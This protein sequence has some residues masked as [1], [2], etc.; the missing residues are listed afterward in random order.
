MIPCFE[1][2]NFLPRTEAGN[3]LSALNYR[4]DLFSTKTVPSFFLREHVMLNALLNDCFIITPW[5]VERTLK[6]VIFLQKNRIV[7]SKV[8]FI[9]H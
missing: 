4:K 8:L 1:K 6:Q 2:A 3:L 7:N 9:M 5:N